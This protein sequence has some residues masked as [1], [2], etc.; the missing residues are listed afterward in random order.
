M[1]VRKATARLLSGEGAVIGE[2]RAYLHLRRPEAE[3]QP[4]Q[5]TVSLDWWDTDSTAQDARLELDGGPT[6][7]LSLES[8]KISGCV[9]GRV[10][11]YSTTWPGV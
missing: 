11:R 9:S 1:S 2:G 3:A 10:L 5:G 6:L 8:D 4:A 7:T